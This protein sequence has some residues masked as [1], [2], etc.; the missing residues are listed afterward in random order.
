[1][2]MIA[3]TA[4]RI[5]PAELRGLAHKR[6]G[7]NLRRAGPFAQL[8]LLG[9]RACLETAGKVPGSSGPLGLLWGSSR[10]AALS[11]QAALEDLRRGD[12]VMPFTFVATQP[13]L[14][15]ALFAQHVHP[16]ARS[17]FLYL[18]PGSEP[19]LAALARHWIGECDRVLVGRVEESAADDAPHQSDWCLLAGAASA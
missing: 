4:L 9:S 7:D 15:A 13:H 16:L 8:T 10:G 2:T 3:P 18:E 12:P 11:T 5:A 1:M 14:G 6:F 19:E 17:A